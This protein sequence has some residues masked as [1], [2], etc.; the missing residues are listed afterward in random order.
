MFLNAWAV[1][2]GLLAAAAP[3]VIHWLTR[4]RPKTLPL[5][6]LR[7]LREV[8]E[9][10]RSRSRLR[11]WV[12]LLL[13]TAA[14][15]LI[16]AAVAR[17]LFGRRVMQTAPDDADVARVV[18][19]DASYSLSAIGR[20]MQHFERARSAAARELTYQPGLA[21]NLIVAAAQPTSLFAGLS[22]NFG[23]LRDELSAAAP[24]PEALH[25]TLALNAAAEQLAAVP[26]GSRR[27]L[28]V[29]SDFQRTNWASADFSALPHDTQIR[30][31][32]VAPE[33]DHPNLA[34]LDARVDG[35]MEVGRPVRLLVEV[36][37][38]S[39]EAR[40]VRVDLRFGPATADGARSLY[41]SVQVAGMCL[42][43]SRTTLSHEVA[44]T[45]P[46]WMAGE[47]TLTVA[48]GGLDALPAD[49]VRTCVWD[50]RPQLEVA[51]ISR[52]SPKQRPSSSYFLERALSTGD[53]PGRPSRTVR[54]LDP[55]Q[56][57]A[58]ALGGAE[59][60]VLDH[61]GPLADAHVN[62][63]A[64]L[65]RR[66]KSVLYIASETA[67]A[68][69]LHRLNQ[70]SERAGGLPVA[71]APRPANQRDEVFVA[72]VRR[73]AAPF[74]VFGDQLP[75]LLR[76]LRIVPGLVSR[77]IDGALRE[78]VLASLIDGSALLA[79]TSS[80][81]GCL[82]V[83]NADL[84][85]SNL[86]AS[87]IFVPML[88]ELIHRRMLSGRRSV[89]QLTCGEPAVVRLP[90]DAPPVSELQLSGPDGAS[91]DVGALELDAGGALL[92]LPASRL[93]GIYTVSR[94]GDVY[95]A[96][97]SAPPALESDLRALSAEVLEQRLA[98]GRHVSYRTES[99]SD[100]QESDTLWSWLA[101]GCVLCVV[102]ELATLKMFGA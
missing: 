78:D 89:T 74:E 76:E 67:D 99:T 24:R 56:L 17:P 72:D 80:E 18:L 86:A 54:R 60:L 79:A 10:R 64:S 59:L 63:L 61:P 27:E 48:G 82:A 25:V 95:W 81:S 84:E 51:L 70:A 100:E 14:V 73:D 34:L 92:R 13:R 85:S 45:E 5:S 4:P 3:V 46:G 94:G 11:D 30:L 55:T 101:L 58:E 7:F 20:E 87:P 32:S 49:N 65:L 39:S 68:T 47:A 2:M 71:F 37:N 33:E 9:Q 88:L 41:S 19:L 91:R 1:A 31:R 23:A 69:N 40:E 83:L 36:G 50:V 29:I 66:G 90:T 102:G 21:A 22:T 52:Q 8:V 26:E 16:A 57:D 53:V 6:T 12:I 43:F 93:P 38:F 42:P 96:G 15:L 75:A 28:I 98:G 35:R 77:P 44:P 97:A 62:Q